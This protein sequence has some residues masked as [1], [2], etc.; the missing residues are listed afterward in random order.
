MSTKL[1]AIQGLAIGLLLLVSLVVPVHVHAASS[2][3]DEQIIADAY[4]YLIGRALVV[5]QEHIDV[6]AQGGYNVAFHNPVGSANFPNP[7]LSVAN[8]EAW[9][10]VD[11]ATPV[12][13]EIPRIEGRY[14]T[15][16]IL[17]EWGETLTNIHERNF[18][19]QP[20]GKFAFVA[21]GSR[22]AIP[23]DAVRIELRSHKA[24]MLAR[25]ELRN[26]RE[27]AVALQRQ[28]KVTPLGTPKF[29]P[30]VKIPTIT[31]PTLV[32][33][34]L[35]DATEDLLKSAPDVSPIAAQ[36]QAQVRAVAL[37]AKDPARRAAI[38][39]TLR[40]A[41][42]PRFNQFAKQEAGLVRNNWF[43]TMVIGNYGEDF[44]IRSTANLI[45][46]WAN[47]THEVVYFVTTRDAAGRPLDGGS[48][49]ELHFPKDALPQDVVNAFW[50]VHLVGLPDFFP[51]P[52]PLNRF[53][54]STYSNVE[55]NPDG[56]LT[57]VL[58][59]E[60]VAGVPKAN[61]LPTAPGKSFSLTWR[62][63]IPKEIVTQGNW[64]PPAVSKRN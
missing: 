9:I 16:H 33:V 29:P 32:G 21:P 13:L 45:G 10:A 57:L 42:I 14:Y 3:L 23:D 5:R 48:T 56:S 4:V 25:V 28:I 17:D 40:D 43:G 63:Y 50:S 6:A 19:L 44:W 61:W 12:L 8:T 27:G 59:P 64:F 41:V 31:E 62:T 11:E 55:K 20:Y 2:A 38:D 47:N 35:F 30:A 52:N 53:V 15:A 37:A 18:P 46:I 22:V 58:A 54:L 51:V 60:P 7:N 34:E 26:D 36:L 49:Y 24:K 1:R 39:K